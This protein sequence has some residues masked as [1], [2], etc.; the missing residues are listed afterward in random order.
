MIYYSFQK[1]EEEKPKPGDGIAIGQ[2]NGDNSNDD[3]N[4]RPIL[5]FPIS[6]KDNDNIAA[7]LRRM[8][9]RDVRQSLLIIRQK[10]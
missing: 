7:M 8:R 1:K 2:D 9:E 6:Q 4:N 10:A 5:H 3:D